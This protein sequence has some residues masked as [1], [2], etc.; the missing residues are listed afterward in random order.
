MENL[1]IQVFSKEDKNLLLSKGYALIKAERKYR[2]D[3]KRNLQNV[4]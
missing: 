4:S 1:F 3:C 2:A